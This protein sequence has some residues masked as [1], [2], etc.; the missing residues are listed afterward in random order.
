[1]KHRLASICSGL[2]LALFLAGGVHSPARAQPSAESRELA[3]QLVQRAELKQLAMLSL[4]AHLWAQTDKEPADPGLSTKKDQ[5]FNLYE[6]LRD[7]DASVFEAPLAK[8]LAENLTPEDLHGL[9]EFYAGPSGNEA[10][11]QVLWNRHQSLGLPGAG[12]YASFLSPPR[13]P[14]SQQAAITRFTGSALFTRM[15]K[16]LA[17][18]NPD[19]AGVINELIRQCERAFV[20]ATV[21]TSTAPPY[22]PL[23][24]RAGIQGSMVIRVRIDASGEAKEARVTRRWFNSR[25]M[26]GLPGKKSTAEVFDEIGVSQAMSSTYAPATRNGVAVESWINIPLRFVLEP[27]SK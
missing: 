16:P 9:L 20:P 5:Y 23:A 24:R 25:D 15:M 21:K 22:P 10:A 18:I 3:L 27:N 2:A 8:L 17:Q 1:M 7:K 19:D 6:C 4:R 14:P 12:E 11:R 13:L 26:P